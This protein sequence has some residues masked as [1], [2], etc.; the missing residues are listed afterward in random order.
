[1]STASTETLFAVEIVFSLVSAIAALELISALTILSAKLNFE[2][3][4][5]ALALTSSL[6]ITPEPI[7]ATPVS[8]IDISPDTTLSIHFDV[9]V[10]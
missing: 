1:M 5:A 9:P 4:I 10:S 8:A 6:T 2:Y 3:T 7:A